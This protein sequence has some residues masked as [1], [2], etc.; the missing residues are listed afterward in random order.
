MEWPRIG[1]GIEAQEK[2]ARAGPWKFRAVAAEIVTKA[3]NEVPGKR[4]D[5]FPS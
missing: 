4:R 2:A 1:K 3:G 5:Q